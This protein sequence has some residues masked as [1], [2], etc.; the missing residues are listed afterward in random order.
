MSKHREPS[1]AVWGKKTL[2]EG[3]INIFKDQSYPRSGIV[4]LLVDER[5]NGMWVRMWKPVSDYHRRKFELPDTHKAAT[6]TRNEKTFIVTRNVRCL[7]RHAQ[8]AICAGAQA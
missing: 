2:T 6:I 3:W 4:R 8:S 1:Y 5:L 7:N